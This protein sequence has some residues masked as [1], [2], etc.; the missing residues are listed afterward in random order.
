MENFNKI[1]IET[2]EL[3]IIGYHGAH[4]F[5]DDLMLKAMIDLF[6]SYSIKI[7]LIAYGPIEWLDPS[8]NICTLVRKKGYKTHNLKLFKDYIKNSS[9]IVSGGGTIFTDEEGDGNFA[10]LLFAKLLGKKIVYYSVGIG[11]LTKITRELK[12]KIMFNIADLMFF[13][14]NYSLKQARKWIIPARMKNAIRIEDAANG[15]IKN[16]IN[17]QS[18]HESSESLKTLVIAW[19]DLGVYATTT[20]G[21]DFDKVSNYCYKL[22]KE[23]DIKKIIIINTD[24]R[25]DG[26]TGSIIG[27]KLI[28][29][30]PDLLVEHNDARLYYEKFLIL[31]SADIIFTS[32]LHVA[33]A[34]HFLKKKCIV[35]NYSPKIQYFFSEYDASNIT[36]EEVL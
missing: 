17:I 26:P 13:R 30:F 12:T 28:G 29:L 32:R 35:Y 18:S 15:I 25:K 10:F 1:L 7:N 20:I 3:T 23:N 33:I 22:V 36:M 14:D 21:N 5:G 31:N 16:M 24:S 34:A 9:L 19:R 8:I 6:L 11:T 27:E 4:N 2:R